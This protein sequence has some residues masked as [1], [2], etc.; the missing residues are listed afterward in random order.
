MPV[1]QS[2]DRQTLFIGTKHTVETEDEA[3]G[4]DALPPTK[5]LG[6]KVS[7]NRTI[8][9]RNTSPSP[10]PSP[11]SAPQTLTRKRTLSSTSTSTQVIELSDTEDDVPANKKT[12]FK[13]QKVALDTATQS[14]SNMNLLVDKL[15]PSEHQH[16]ESADRMDIQND[17]Y[18]TTGE[19]SQFSDAVPQPGSTF[20]PTYLQYPAD[21]N[22]QDH[23]PMLPKTP[24]PDLTIHP[25]ALRKAT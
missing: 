13:R 18:I 8:H 12:N 15:K 2:W 22:F 16:Q 5:K 6:E 11:S 14:L 24:F 7:V 21:F 17:G 19:Q 20:E 3:T 1:N 4:S 9:T 23:V 25:S 10:S